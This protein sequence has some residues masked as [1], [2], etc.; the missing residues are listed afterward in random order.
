MKKSAKPYEQTGFAII[1]SHG[2]AMQLAT[3]PTPKP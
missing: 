1:N 2:D 3:R